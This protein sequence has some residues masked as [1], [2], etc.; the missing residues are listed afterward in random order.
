MATMGS[1]TIPNG[2]FHWAVGFGHSKF[3]FCCATMGLTACALASAIMLIGRNTWPKKFA[4]PKSSKSHQN[5]LSLFSFRLLGEDNLDDLNQ[6]LVDRINDD[7]RV[8][9]TQTNLDGMRVIRFQ[10][11]QFDCT[12]VDVMA[13]YDAILDA[14]KHL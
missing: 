13:T 10:A 8:Y 9:L 6:R 1:S 12:E 3:G 14:V 5:P 7:G 2:R 4:P 11:G